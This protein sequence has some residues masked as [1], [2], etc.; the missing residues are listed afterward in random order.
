MGPAVQYTS[1]KPWDALEIEVYPGADGK[2]TLYEDEGDGYAY[3]Q[4]AYSTIDLSWDDAAGRFEIAARKGSFSGMLAQRD[5]VIRVQGH[6]PVT[7]H[8]TG[9]RV[10]TDIE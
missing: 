1:E 4:G 10:K 6:E 5:F 2:F 9:K 7:V 3:E 8:Y